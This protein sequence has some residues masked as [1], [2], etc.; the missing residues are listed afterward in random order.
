MEPSLQAQRASVERQ[1]RSAGPKPLPDPTPRTVSSALQPCAPIA[2][3]ELSRL[4]ESS[5][6]D[7]GV[8]PS[9]I[10]EVAR[11]E[12]AFHPCAVSP[13]GAEGLMQLMPSTQALFQVDDPFNP[14]QS[15]DAGTRLLRQLLDRYKGDLTRAFGAYN[16]GA[17]TVDQAGG[18][19]EIPETREYVRDIMLRLANPK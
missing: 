2:A 10:R 1:K 17:S 5:A 13:A 19:P 11:Q 8:N 12:S 9:L 6:R 15:I 7:Q 18:V 4:I 16:A 14:R 3:P